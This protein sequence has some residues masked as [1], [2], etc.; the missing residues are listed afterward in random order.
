MHKKSGQSKK[1]I[2]GR[3]D[4]LTEF[5]RLRLEKGLRQQD[6]ADRS[7]IPQHRLSYLERGLQPTKAEAEALI[8]ILVSDNKAEKGR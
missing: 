6:V 5:K 8:R 2:E 7:G 4:V 3:L 1:I